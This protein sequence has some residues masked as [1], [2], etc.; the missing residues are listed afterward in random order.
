[1]QNGSRNSPRTP[2]RSNQRFV[3]SQSHNLTLC[4][5]LAREL[6]EQKMLEGP[7]HTQDHFFIY[8]E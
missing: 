8:D 2:T 3:A 5:K 1:M 7:W 6:A 4:L